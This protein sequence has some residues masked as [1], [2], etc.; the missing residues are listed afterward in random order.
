MSTRINI[1]NYEAFLLDWTEGNL[2]NEDILLLKEFLSQHP[3]ISIDEKLISEPISLQKNIVFDKKEN[4]KKLIS[5]DDIIAYH[6]GN[7]NSIQKKDVEDFIATD[8]EL[9]K[10]FE[11]YGKLKLNP[12]QIVFEHKHLLKKKGAVI[13]FKRVVYAASSIAALW[14][15]FMLFFSPNQQYTPVKNIAINNNSII[16]D[17][18]E[19]ISFLYPKKPKREERTLINKTQKK[20]NRNTIDVE[21]ELKTNESLIEP[22]FDMLVDEATNNNSEINFAFIDEE[23]NNYGA[24]IIKDHSIKSVKPTEK[25]LTIKQFLVSKLKKNVLK[26]NDEN[27]TKLEVDDFAIMLAG[28]SKDKITLTKKGNEDYI[29][30]HTRYFSFNRKI[31]N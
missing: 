5:E 1:E 7:L 23:E 26:V 16:E 11:L 24:V 29:N 14:L 30:I 8:S 21:N 27:P 25:K 6:E 22:G 17:D 19:D 20:V 18:N 9:I 2:S 12:E 28:V 15:F 31:S 10:D 4:L 3:E 13:T